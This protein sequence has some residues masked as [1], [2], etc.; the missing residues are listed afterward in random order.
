MRIQGIF[1][2]GFHLEQRISWSPSGVQNDH[3]WW[4]IIK[5]NKKL[6]KEWISGKFAARA[7]AY[8]TFN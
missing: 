2:Y 5:G 3:E 6:L 7:Q 1:V 4:R 8:I